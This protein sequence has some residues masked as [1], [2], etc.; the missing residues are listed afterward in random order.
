[1]SLAT[2]ISLLS[3][4]MTVKEI[5]YRYKQMV[6]KDEMSAWKMKSIGGSNGA[7]SQVALPRPAIMA[8]RPWS[9]RNDTL[10]FFSIRY[11]GT[12]S[13]S[14]ASSPHP[15]LHSETWYFHS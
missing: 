4:S 14:T 9:Y 6:W 13:S 3:H 7:V 12:H 15:Q 8:Y 2:Q 10:S 5:H 11:N 1:M